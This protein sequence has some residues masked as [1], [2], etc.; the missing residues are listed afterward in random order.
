M[1]RWIALLA[2]FLPPPQAERVLILVPLQAGASWQDHAYLAAIPAACELGNKEPMVLAVQA[3]AP[4]SPEVDFACARGDPG[5]SR[6][7]I[8]LFDSTLGPKSL[9]GGKRGWGSPP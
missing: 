3:N 5:W 6:G 7:P 4:W 8:P 9:L 2:F 1:F